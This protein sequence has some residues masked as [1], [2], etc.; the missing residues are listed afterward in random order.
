MEK[1]TYQVTKAE[2]EPRSSGLYP[3]MPPNNPGFLPQID[4]ADVSN[5]EKV[6]AELLC[7]THFLSLK[8][9]LT[10]VVSGC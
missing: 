1:E 10:G 2:P 8:R 4:R 3:D 6:R 5:D 9:R 7:V